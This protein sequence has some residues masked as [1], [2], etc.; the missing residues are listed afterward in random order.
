MKRARW[1]IK[2]MSEVQRKVESDH[3]VKEETRR[4]EP[5]AQSS[6]DAN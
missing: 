2:A 5:T 3:E 4:E 6:R 1:D